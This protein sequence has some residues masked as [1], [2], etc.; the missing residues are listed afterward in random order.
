MSRIETPKKL[1]VVKNPT[2]ESP[3]EYCRCCK[4][5]LKLQYGDSWK[6]LSTE[7][8][9]KPSNKKGIEGQILAQVLE[10]VGIEVTRNSKLSERLCKP[11]ASKIRR[12]CEG[13]TFVSRTLNVVNPKFVAVNT[14][15]ESTDC[16]PRSKRALPSS[17]STPERSPG[18]KKMQKV[19]SQFQGPSSEVEVHRTTSAGAR[20]SLG[21][22]FQD[23]F[24][25][26][27]VAIRENEDSL[28][29]IDDILDPEL[30]STRV[31]VLTLWP[32]GRTDVRVPEAREDILLLK[33]IASKN[34]QAVANAVVKHVELKPEILKALWRV[35]NSE[36]RQY[37][38]SKSVLK[39]VSPE[40]LI[41]FS[42]NIVLD[43]MI[44][45]CPYWS[46]CIGGACGV[47]LKQNGDLQDFV[48]NSV[49][50]ATSLTARVR[51]KCMSAL[52]YRVSS[53]L[54]HSG[55]SQQDLIRLNRLGI[56]MSPDRI[57]A[58]QR[59]LGKNF[60]GKV[61]S[62]KKAL[63]E[64]PVE[65]LAFLMEIEDKQVPVADN[66][67]VEVSIDLTEE[68]LR[69]YKHFTAKAFSAVS[70]ML[71]TE[72]EKRNCGIISSDIL[73]QVISD[74]KKFNFPFFK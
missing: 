49:A 16:H 66:M 3:N 18:A 15:S 41:A 37:C 21:M 27:I 73:K 74:H 10:Q 59:N 63:E 42:S 22:E 20:K 68:S 69:S 39:G 30:Q 58:L 52:A 34:W 28:L 71:Q 32:S 19:S 24:E 26:P 46:S 48:K 53:V 70:K 6:S 45:S 25:L 55:V 4:C 9:F 38:S 13:M 5:S 11:C 72:K 8:L 29:N 57:L 44:S 56:C 65:T 12:A 23:N 7:N 40:E 1:C 64:K 60:D 2:H 47:D 61:L 36:F 35:F 62:Y 33:N 31:K 51:N 17:V 67:E 43:E 54:L 14:C 50:L